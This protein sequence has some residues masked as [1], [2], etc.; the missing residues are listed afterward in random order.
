MTGID[1]RGISFTPG[2]IFPV[3]F[4]SLVQSLDDP[5]REK[6]DRNCRLER[7]TPVSFTVT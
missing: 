7:K 4:V 5:L 3:T 2:R 6:F 1:F